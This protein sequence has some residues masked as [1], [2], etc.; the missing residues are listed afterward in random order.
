MGGF[1]TRGRG[2]STVEGY[3][4]DCF[5]TTHRPQTIHKGQLSARARNTKHLSSERLKVLHRNCSL[6]GWSYLALLGLYWGYIGLMEKKMETT[7]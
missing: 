6:S 4:L 2:S 3:S 1:N 5:G 7:I